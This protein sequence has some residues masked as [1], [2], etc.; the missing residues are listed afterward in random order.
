MLHGLANGV[1]L[2]H[3]KFWPIYER[4]EALDVPIYMHPG[5]P[6]A[7]VRRVYYDDYVKDFPMFT[8]ATWG[9]TVETATLAIRMVLSGVFEKYPKLKIVLGHL[10]ET[11]PF[12][13]WRIDHT[14]ARPGQKAMSFRDVFCKNFYVTTSGNFSNPALLCC[15]M[16]LGI[17]RILFAVDWP[18]VSNQPGTRW[19]ESVPL[20]DEDKAKI[21]SGNAKRILKM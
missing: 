10:G 3:K 16:E 20:C 11:L 8:R 13:V 7:E 19:M 12:L 9:Y 17:D 14:L 5:L 1:F 6:E 18:F 21:L 15:V 2:D 4:A